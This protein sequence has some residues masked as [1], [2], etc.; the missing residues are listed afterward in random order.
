MAKVLSALGLAMAEGAAEKQKPLSAFK[1]GALM[2]AK[3][4]TVY[5]LSNV[6]HMGSVPRMT[7]TKVGP[8]RPAGMSS[9]Q[10]DRLQKKQRRLARERRARAA[11]NGN[12]GTESL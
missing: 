9:R 6:K 10:W 7:L 4:G 11:N 2:K 3:D 12:P 5:E 1:D 8:Q